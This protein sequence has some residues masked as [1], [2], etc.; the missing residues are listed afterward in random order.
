MSRRC[1]LLAGGSCRDVI[2]EAGFA[3]EVAESAD[4]SPSFEGL[5]G[6]VLDS[7]EL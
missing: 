1:C 2:G 4:S 6:S 3:D 7:F 5:T